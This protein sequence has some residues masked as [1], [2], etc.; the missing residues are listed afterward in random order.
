LNG[1]ADVLTRSVRI[2][3]CR[4]EIAGCGVRAPQ[5]AEELAR[6]VVEERRGIVIARPN[7]RTSPFLRVTY[8]IRIHV[9][10]ATPAAHSEGVELTSFA[11]AIAGRDLCAATGIYRTRSVANP[12]RIE[13]SHARV[14]GI[15]HAVGI[16]IRLTATPAHAEHVRIGA[17][18][19]VGVCRTVIVASGQVYATAVGTRTVFV[20][21]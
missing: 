4:I 20:L 12:A 15:A 13:R 1:A 14:A 7:E 6:A 10:R 21:R 3:G 2:D 19:I 18:A 8:A 11:V 9:C 17:R 16:G 5:T